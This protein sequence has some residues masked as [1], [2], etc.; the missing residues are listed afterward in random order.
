MELYVLYY[1][2]VESERKYNYGFHCHGKTNFFLHLNKLIIQGFLEVWIQPSI[3]T[4]KKST[5]YFFFKK[6][7][8]S[9]FSLEK[10]KKEHKC[11][12]YFEKFKIRICIIRFFFM[13]NVMNHLFPIE[14]SKCIKQ[15]HLIHIFFSISLHTQIIETICKTCLLISNSKTNL[16]HLKTK[17]EHTVLFTWTYSSY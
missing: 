1:S 11:V 13:W 9:I 15:N 14:Q 12:P 4:L 2:I 7:Q 5:V 16:L 17:G 3:F 6:N 10:S 8:P